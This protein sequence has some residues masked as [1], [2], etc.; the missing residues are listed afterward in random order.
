MVCFYVVMLLSK[1]EGGNKN[2]KKG[3]E[4][5]DNREREKRE[6]SSEKM[7]NVR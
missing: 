1:Q 4:N 6:G 5:Y 3:R 7:I 2:N